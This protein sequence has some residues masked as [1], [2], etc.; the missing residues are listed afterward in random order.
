MT[1][2][3]F[4]TTHAAHIIFLLISGALGGGVPIKGSSQRQFDSVEGGWTL[5]KKNIVTQKA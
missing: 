4:K 1:L 3:T 5:M 2:E